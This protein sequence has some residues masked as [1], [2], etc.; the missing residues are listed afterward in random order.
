M[1]HGVVTPLPRIVGPASAKIVG[2]M[3]PEGV[4]LSR[5]R[6]LSFMA[7]FHFRR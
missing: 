5:H 1:A 3:I 2:E 6:F 4:R 7:Y